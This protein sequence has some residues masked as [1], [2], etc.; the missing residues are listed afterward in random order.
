MRPKLLAGL[1]VVV[2]A[3][4]A[5]LILMQGLSAV[6]S[7]VSSSSFAQTVSSG[8]PVTQVAASTG[9]CSRAQ[10]RVGKEIV[11]SGSSTVG[12][13]ATYFAIPL[14]NEGADCRL[15]LPTH[16]LVESTDGISRSVSVLRQSGAVYR[17]KAGRVF[18]IQVSSWEAAPLSLVTARRCADPM[19]NVTV[20]ALPL[21]DGHLWFTMTRALGTVCASRASI[22]FSFDG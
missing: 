13:V 2:G 10:L 8:K 20:L 19:S 5:S 1:G 18:T 7:R 21:P 3:V 11:E 14:T 16:I 4:A 6:P 12:S 17:L 15:R 22:S 9:Y